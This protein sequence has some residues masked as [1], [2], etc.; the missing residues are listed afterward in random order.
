[1]NGGGGGLVSTGWRVNTLAIL[2]RAHYERVLALRTLEAFCAVECVPLA[3][4][5]KRIMLLLLLCVMEQVNP[6]RSAP[7]AYQRASLF[8][9]T[10]PISLFFF[11][12]DERIV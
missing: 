7:T 11:F 1:M 8:H 6:E 4:S 3:F 10:P 9:C 2:S 5:A 12:W